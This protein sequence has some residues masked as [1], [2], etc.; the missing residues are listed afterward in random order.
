MVELDQKYRGS[1][2]CMLNRYNLALDSLLKAKGLT[3]EEFNAMSALEQGEIK[4]LAFK[5][6]GRNMQ[7]IMANDSLAA[8]QYHLDEKNSMAFIELVKQHGWLTDKSLGCSQKFRTVLIFRHAPKKY[9]P[10]IRELIEK[11]K[12]AQRIPPY[13]YYIVDNHLKGRPPLDKSASDFNNG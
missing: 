10:Q 12:A 8:L 7:P 11:E 6:G 4:S 13:E 1:N 9:W 2:D 5:I 3:H